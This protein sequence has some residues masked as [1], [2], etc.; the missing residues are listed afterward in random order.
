MNQGVK[1]ALVLEI[2][3]TKSKFVKKLWKK[4]LKQTVG[5]SKKI[6]KS[7]EMIVAKT[8]IVEV[9]GSQALDL[10]SRVTETGDDVEVIMW[11]S[12]EEN[13]FLSSYNYP[14]QCTEAEKILMRFALEVT[15]EKIKI[16]LKEEEDRLKK[17]EKDLKR[18]K[19]DNVNFH[20]EIKIAEEKI[21]KAKANISQNEIEQETMNATIESQKELIEEVKKRLSEI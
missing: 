5:K 2:P 12:M 18:L 3:D 4:Y 16:E 6:K 17:Q 21:K 13:E 10:I 15:R 14:D 19:R 7:D 1:N 8:R 9:G 20:R 11:I